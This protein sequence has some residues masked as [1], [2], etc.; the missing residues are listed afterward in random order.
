MLLAECS[1]YDIFKMTEALKMFHAMSY[2]VS[3]IS[4][5]NRY[6]KKFP[7]IHCSIDLYDNMVIMMNDKFRD[8]KF[9]SETMMVSFR[10]SPSIA[11]GRINQLPKHQ[12]IIIEH[13]VNESLFFE[14]K[15][16]FSSTSEVP[17][18]ENEDELFQNRLLYTESELNAIYIYHNFDEIIVEAGSYLRI[19]EKYYDDFIKLYDHLDELRDL[20]YDIK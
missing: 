2:D 17:V 4:K 11:A 10:K 19:C 18:L 13:A 5:A 6:F 7:K 8:D 1:K 9:H 12:S 16:I 20:M 14:N 15:L 3:A